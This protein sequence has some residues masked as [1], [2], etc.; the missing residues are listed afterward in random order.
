MLDNFVSWTQTYEGY[1][2]WFYCDVLGYVTIGYGNLADPYALVSGLTFVNTDDT[3]STPAQVLAAWKAVK[4]LHALAPEGGGTFA[5][6]TSVR[7][8]KDSIIKLCAAKLAQLES[9]SR[10]FFPGWDDFPADGQLLVMSM[11]WAMGA[12]A[13][14]HWPHFCAAVNAGDWAAVA[15]PHGEPASCQMNEDG[16]NASFKARNAANM[17]LALNAAQAVTNGTVEA[18]T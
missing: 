17:Q 5:R 7:A 9:Q 6:F 18:L 11:S 14:A 3:P 10:K 4:A 16:Q 13:F 8:T 2:S 15:V 1:V 12:L